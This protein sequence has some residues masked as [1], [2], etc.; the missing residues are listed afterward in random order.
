MDVAHGLGEPRISVSMLC[1]LAVFS[2]YVLCCLSSYMLLRY[3]IVYS[4]NVLYLM[5]QMRMIKEDC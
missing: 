1:S 3:F 5:I 4:L 2:S